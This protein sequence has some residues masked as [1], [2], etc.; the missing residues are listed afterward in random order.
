VVVGVEH[1]VFCVFSSAQLVSHT[2]SRMCLS[3]SLLHGTYTVR[4]ERLYASESIHHTV[5]VLAG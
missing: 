3:M 5:Q 4:V 1:A 2:L